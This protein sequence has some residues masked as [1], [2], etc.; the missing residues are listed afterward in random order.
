[1]LGRFPDEIFGILFPEFLKNF[2]QGKVTKA[3][4]DTTTVYQKKYPSTGARETIHQP[5]NSYLPSNI[6][7]VYLAARKSI[8]GARAAPP[9]GFS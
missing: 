7:T 4:V 8:N 5:S 9:R 2:K 1:L 3:Q 6:L